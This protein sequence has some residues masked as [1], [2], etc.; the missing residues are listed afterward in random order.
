MSYSIFEK[1]FKDSFDSM[2]LKGWPDKM[3]AHCM[4]D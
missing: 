2:S 4:M 1:D 3:Y